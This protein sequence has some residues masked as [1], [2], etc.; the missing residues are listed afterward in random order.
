MNTVE[1]LNHTITTR[2]S[3][4]AMDWLAGRCAA[5]GRSASQLVREMVEK[6]YQEDREG[7][8]QV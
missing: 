7:S 4:R 8:D 2:L 6:A 5:T 1:K 3:R